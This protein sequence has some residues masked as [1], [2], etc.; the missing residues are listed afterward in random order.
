MT[1][2]Q[3]SASTNDRNQQRPRKKNNNYYKKKKN[4]TY[5]KQYENQ[6]KETAE[7]ICPEPVQ[8]EKKENM[9]DKKPSLN[10]VYN[11]YKR[12]NKDRRNSR[13][14]IET[15]DDIKKDITRIEKEIRLEIEEI[16]MIRM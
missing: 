1:D 13:D 14:T 4:Y 9:E 10:K 11:N 16:K 6:S 5:N 8:T 3:N 15:I 7:C 12:Y 2:N